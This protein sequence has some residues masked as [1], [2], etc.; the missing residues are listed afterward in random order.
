MKTRRT[1]CGILRVQCPAI[2]RP[3]VLHPRRRRPRSNDDTQIPI[4]S[5]DVLQNVKNVRGL[6]VDIE[7]V[8]TGVAADVVKTI[9][10]MM[11]MSAP[12]FSRSRCLD[13]PL[14]EKSEAPMGTRTNESPAAWAPSVAED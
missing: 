14:A 3:A 11:A 4:D 10:C 12:C 2:H 7:L 1:L 5:P 8:E 6:V 13:K 9:V